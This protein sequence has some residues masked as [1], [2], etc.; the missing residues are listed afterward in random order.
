MGGTI[1]V[2]RVDARGELVCSV[3][4][5][6]CRRE[7]LKFDLTVA[8]VGP[9]GSVFRGSLADANAPASKPTSGQRFRMRY[10]KL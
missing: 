8:C 2:V 10:L 9:D 7:I 3:P 4:C 1:S 6:F 5:V